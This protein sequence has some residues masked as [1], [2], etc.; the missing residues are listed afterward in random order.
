MKFLIVEDDFASR[1]FLQVVLSD[2][3]DCYIA[4]NGREATQAFEQSLREG[5]PYDLVCLDIRM[6]VMNGL[7]C[8]Q[9][10]RTL[11]REDP[12]GGEPTKVIVTTA[13]TDRPVRATAFETGCEAYL[14]KPIEKETL[15]NELKQL[16]IISGGPVPSAD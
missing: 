5:E 13:I 4:V 9:Q 8:L 7:E 12:D 15:I 1:R 3:G 10:I 6:P 2:Y 14:V 16:G 11:E